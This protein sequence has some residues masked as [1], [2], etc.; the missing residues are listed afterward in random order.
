MGGGTPTAW[1]NASADSGFGPS[2]PDRRSAYVVCGIARY[3][4]VIMIGL[5]GVR[6]F[7]RT[8]SV[9]RFRPPCGARFA[10]PADARCSR[11]GGHGGEERGRRAVL[12]VAAARQERRASG[13]VQRDPATVRGS[14]SGAAVCRGAAGRTAIGR[15]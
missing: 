8:R 4:T 2:V 13:A 9:A 3:V 10:K 12:P 5:R 11:G 6:H 15:I 7:R 1:M 14:A